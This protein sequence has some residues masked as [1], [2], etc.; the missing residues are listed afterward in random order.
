M[1]LTI[2]QRWKFVSFRL[3]RLNSIGRLGKRNLTRSARHCSASEIRRSQ[4][5]DLVTTRY[6]VAGRID[7]LRHLL[8]PPASPKVC[9]CVTCTV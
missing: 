3:E 9:I 1:Y 8:L 2:L 4:M 7:Q 6:R 5:L